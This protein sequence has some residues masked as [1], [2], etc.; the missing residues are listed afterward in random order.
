MEIKPPEEILKPFRAMEDVINTLWGVFDSANWRERWCEGMLI[1]GPHWFSFEIASI[2]G[3]VHFYARILEDWRN[4]FESA[5]YSYYPEAEI[6]VAKDYTQDV[7][8]NVPN[9]DWD[10]YSEDFTLMKEQ[11]YPVRTYPI[12]FEEKPEV[13]EEEKR[14]DPMDS[15][16]EA[17]TKLQ[18]GEQFWLQIVSAPIK[19][20]DIPWITRGKEVVDKLAK[21]PESKKPKPILQEAIEILVGGKKEKEVKE[22]GLVAPELRLTMGEKEIIH[23]VEN[24]IA[25]YGFKTS[26]RMLYIYNVH[27]P[28]F[29]GNYKIGRSYL[30]HFSTENLNAFVFLGPTRTRI[31]YWLRAR[32]LYLRKRKNLRHFVER[33]PPYFPWN[34][35]G[36][37]V[38]LI[39]FG[40]YP[41]GPGL[42]RR[43]TMVLNAEELASVYHFPS[44]IKVPAVPRVEAKKAGP[45]AELPVE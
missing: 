27:E 15:L 32:R 44:K 17:L 22:E 42:W 1:Q 5:I 21:R 18:S 43:G 10:L 35:E 41:R 24:K 37:P 6:S 31:H 12:F 39:D 26:I 8:Q 28:H 14:I 9:K 38:H 13:S 19:D 25:K 20:S 33:F 45:P 40:R 3:V 16:M 23:G 30:S 34:T 4:M 11:I 36:K 29:M 2:K 7:P